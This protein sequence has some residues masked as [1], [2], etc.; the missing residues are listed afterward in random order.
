MASW[1][2]FSKEPVSG[3]G[4]HLEQETEPSTSQADA[5]ELC[6]SSEDV[7]TEPQRKKPRLTPSGTNLSSLTNLIGKRCIRGFSALTPRKAF[8]AFAK[9]GELHL[10]VSFYWFCYAQLH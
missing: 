6:E 2:Y 8:V 10:Q 9:N 5:V 7:V 3:S 4:S 1:K